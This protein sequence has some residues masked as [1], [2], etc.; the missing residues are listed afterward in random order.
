VDVA[1]RAYLHGRRSPV[2]WTAW[3]GGNDW[4]EQEPFLPIPPI[5]PFLPLLPVLSG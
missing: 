2:G 5:L 1:E 3:R 4:R